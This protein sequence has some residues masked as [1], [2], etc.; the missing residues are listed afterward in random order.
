MGFERNIFLEMMPATVVRSTRSGHT[1]YGAASF[2]AATT[3][4]RARIVDKPGFTRNRDGEDVGYRSVAWLA[5][6][7][8]LDISDRFTLPDGTAPPVVA[9]EKYPDDDGCHHYKLF[10]GW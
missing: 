7:G 5:S 2:A 9:F 1:N 3:S 10:F 6:T 4:I 8:V